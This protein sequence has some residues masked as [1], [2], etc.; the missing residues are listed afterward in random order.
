MGIMTRVSLKKCR[1]WYLI[2]ECLQSIE[3]HI[4]EAQL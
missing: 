1:E 3:Q 2:E 4:H